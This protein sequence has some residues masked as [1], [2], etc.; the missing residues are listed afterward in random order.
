MSHTTAISKEVINKTQHHTFTVLRDGV[1]TDRDFVVITP[2]PLAEDYNY[3]FK[4]ETDAWSWLVMA[5]ENHVSGKAW[6]IEPK[7]K[8]DGAQV[9]YT[10]L[11]DALTSDNKEVKEDFL[12]FP[13]KTLVST[14]HIWI[15]SYFS[16]SIEKDLINF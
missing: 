1:A 5:R 2:A 10:A 7:D 6:D 13:A 15:E 14:I 12:F 9:L 16:V 11:S 3:C 8:H 4:S